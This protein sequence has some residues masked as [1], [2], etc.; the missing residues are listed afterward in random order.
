[1]TETAVD[2]AVDEAEKVDYTKLIRMARPVADALLLQGLLVE[3]EDA[4]VDDLNYASTLLENARELSYELSE[5][6]DDLGSDLFEAL[7]KEKQGISPDENVNP[8][9]YQLVGAPNASELATGVKKEISEGWNVSGSV[10]IGPDGSFY[11]PMTK[12]DNMFDW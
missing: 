4:L 3:I 1:M 5:K 9:D 11:Q 6:I 10:V 12:L 8:M 2:V 7:H